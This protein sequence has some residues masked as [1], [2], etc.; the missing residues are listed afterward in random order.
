MTYVV[1]RNASNQ[2]PTYY[3]F[4]YFIFSHVLYENLKDCTRMIEALPFENI[5][6]TTH[7][8]LI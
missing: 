4:G 7:D 6:L 5:F 8:I 3:S 2:K 1:S